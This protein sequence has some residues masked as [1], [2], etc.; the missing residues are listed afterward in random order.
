VDDGGQAVAGPDHGHVAVEVRAPYGYSEP[1]QL[2]QQ[3]R[4]RVTVIVVQAN[5]D[6]RNFRMH[7]REECGIGVRR[8]VVRHLEH[9]GVNV[10]AGG[11]HRLLCLDLGVARQQ[12]RHAAH[13]GPHDE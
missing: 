8:A 1:G 6:H 11:E 12:D 5:G 10:D 9:V 3:Q 4:T 2:G 7:A 13:D